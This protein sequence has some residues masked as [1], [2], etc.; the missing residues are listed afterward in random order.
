MKRIAYC[1]S[2]SILPLGLLFACA[3]AKPAQPEGGAARPAASTP[4]TPPPTRTASG[5]PVGR[6]LFAGGCFWC[7]QPPFDKVDGVIATRVGFA[8]GVRK[9][10]TYQEVSSGKTRHTEAIEVR[11]DPAKVSYER[12][13]R[14]FWRSMDPTDTGGQFADRGSQY[15]PAIFYLSEAQ[16]KTA[17]RSKAALAAS[18]RFKKPVVVPIVPATA[19]YPA[20]RYHQKYYLT[21]PARYRGYKVGSGRAGFLK[22]VWGPK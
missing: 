4:A 21:N 16:R 18:G 20:E 11:F 7:M 1:T 15:R 19:F 14:V 6:A 2:L 5:A 8:G 12:L 9:N 10:P 3:P 17:E 22:R 13:L